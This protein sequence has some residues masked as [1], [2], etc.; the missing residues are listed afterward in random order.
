MILEEKGVEYTI[1][2]KKEGEEE[3]KNHKRDDAKAKS[4][5]IQCLPDK[6]LEI[7]KKCESSSMLENLKSIFERK[8][9][10]SKLH[11]KKQLLA[12]KCGRQENLQDHFLKFDTLVAK[13][14]T[15]GSK[16]EES[17]KVC[18]LLLTLLLN[19]DYDQVIT[20]LETI[21]KE[22]DMEFV[23]SKLM[24]A[25]LKIK[26][27]EKESTDEVN[28]YIKC[29]KCG[30]EGQKFYEC[31]KK[32]NTY[33]RGNRGRSR[34]R[35]PRGNFR[36]RAASRPAANVTDENENRKDMFIACE[37]DVQ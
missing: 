37:N 9:V 33:Y 18:H 27:K 6:Y 2:G 24:D 26:G 22:L 29:Y 13:L 25:E 30:K 36:L 16:M 28:F 1:K 12:L 14:E 19:E 23:K 8:S 5:I 10:F 4:I 20:T 7:V 15:M 17:D 11:L 35:R 31:K 21:D 34:A 3:P 32:D